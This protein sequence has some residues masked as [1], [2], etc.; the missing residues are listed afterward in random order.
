[1]P[2]RWRSNAA[3]QLVKAARA[4]GGTVERAAPG[5]VKVTGPRG[6]ITLQEPSGGAQRRDLRRDSA[7]QKI[8][9]AT[10]LD[11]CPLQALKTKGRDEHEPED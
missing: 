11:L 1:M 5:R 6:A 7:A 3:R 9:K 2:E 8:A 10:G 4:A